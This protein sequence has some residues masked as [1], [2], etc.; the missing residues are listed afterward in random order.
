MKIAQCIN[1][2]ASGIKEIQGQ[3]GV[4]HLAKRTDITNLALVVPV[5]HALIFF[6]HFLYQKFRGLAPLNAIVSLPI[7][8]DG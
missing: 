1:P 3:P 2:A 7:D 5:V 6:S 4:A 8:E